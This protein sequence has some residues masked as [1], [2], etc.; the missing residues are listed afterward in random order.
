[1]S[2]PTSPG[3]EEPAAPT[4][5][6]PTDVTQLGPTGWAARR[7]GRSAISLFVI[8]VL[9]VI[10][11][12]T[13]PEGSALASTSEP[14]IDPIIDVTGLDQNWALFAPDPRSSTKRLEARLTYAD[15][16]VT[17]W[18]P[19]RW[20]RLI[21]VYRGYRYRKWAGWVMGD[22]EQLHPWAATWLA[23]TN[24]RD[25]QPPVRVELL[26][27]TY[28]PPPP[29]SGLGP[30]PSPDWQIEPLYTAEFEVSP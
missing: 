17:T 1:M 7:L 8:A 11:L 9:A 2:A 19:P 23:R 27:L 12:D 14:V 22:R 16:T 21:G 18:S 25:G 24:L 5:G 13:T 29:G 20:D 4:L 28:E 26:E 15:G 30:D 6:A 3:P 10:L